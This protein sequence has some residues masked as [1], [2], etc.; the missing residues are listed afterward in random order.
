MLSNDNIIHILSFC[1]LDWKYKLRSTS[2]SMKKC[3]DDNLTEYDKCLKYH[4]Q[5][6]LKNKPTFICN[7]IYGFVAYGTA[8]QI[9]DFYGKYMLQSNYIVGVA[10]I[11]ITDLETSNV[12]YDIE[13]IVHNDNLL[14]CLD[15]IELHQSDSE[16]YLISNGK[17]YNNITGLTKMDKF[18]IAKLDQYGKLKIEFD[19]KSRQIINKII[20]NKITEIC[21]GTSI[22][23]TIIYKEKK[24]FDSLKKQELKQYKFNSLS[25]Y[26]NSRETII[27]IFNKF[28]KILEIND[29]EVILDKLNEYG[30]IN[31]Y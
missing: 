19:M 30:L 22:E 24:T 5:I 2:K 21:D 3:I 26:G 18:I 7:K 12:I 27:K 14:N 13:L 10:I 9:T 8:Y 28:Y 1:K 29:K 17:G 16:L 15:N 31:T 23:T 25:Q 11:R 20:I 6:H 4:K